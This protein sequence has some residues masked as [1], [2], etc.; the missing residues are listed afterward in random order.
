MYLQKAVADWHI[1]RFPEAEPYHV[2]IKAMEELGEVASALNGDLAKNDGRKREGSVPKEVGDVI[3]CL[4]VLLGRWYPEHD[5]LLE[6][7]EKLNILTDPNSGHRSAALPESNKD[8]SGFGGDPI[9]KELIKK[10]VHVRQ[11]YKCRCGDTC[12]PGDC[13]NVPA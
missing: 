9:D 13:W 7:M 1:N 12:K 4:M 5:A 6:V 3:I 2:M 8:F 10:V 11:E